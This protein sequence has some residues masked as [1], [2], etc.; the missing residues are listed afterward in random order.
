MILKSFGQRLVRELTIWMQLHHPNVLELYGASAHGPYGFA[1]VSPWMEHGNV[2]RY[3]QSTPEAKRTPL[4]LDVIKGLQY[5]HDRSIVHGNLTGRNVLVNQA[6][7]ACLADF[8]LAWVWTEGQESEASESS[9][10]P[11]GTLRWM[12]PERVIPEHYGMTAAS[13][14]T[15]AADI[16]SFAMVAYEIISGSMPFA[17]IR[18]PYILFQQI[19]RGDRPKRPTSGG[20]Y[21]AFDDALWSTIEDCWKEDWRA[22]PKADI[23]VDEVTAAIVPDRLEEMVRMHSADLSRDREDDKSELERHAETS[24]QEE[25]PQVTESTLP[26]T[27]AI[28]LSLLLKDNPLLQSMTNVTPFLQ[29]V[30]PAAVHTGTRRAIWTAEYNGQRVALKTARIDTSSSHTERVKDLIRE[31]SIWSRLRHPN[32]LELYGFC[33]LES[34]GFAMV[35]RWMENGSLV[36]YLKR[37][38]SASRLPWMYDIAEGLSYLHRQAPPIVHGDLAGRNILIK[39][40][41]GACLADFGLS[42]ILSADFGLSRVFP[43]NMGNEASQTSIARGNP[44]W[45]APERL[46]PQ[47]YGL[48]TSSSLTISSDIYSFGMVVYEL[49]TGRIPFY[50]VSNQLSIPAMVEAGVRPSHPGEE[51]VQLGLSPIVWDMMQECWKEDYNTRPEGSR[52]VQMIA[53]LVTQ[54]D[55]RQTR[56]YMDSLKLPPVIWEEVKPALTLTRDITASIKSISDRPLG[57]GGLSDVWTGSYLGVKVA[58]KARMRPPVAEDERI[59]V[60]VKEIAIRARLFHPNILELYGFSTHEPPGFAMV[61][62][63]MQHGDLT[64]YLHASVGVPRVQLMLDIAEGLSYLHS[65]EPPIVHC[66]LK[67][68]NVLIKNDG[69]ACIAGFSL[70]R[71]LAKDAGDDLEEEQAAMGNIRWMA[72]ERAFPEKHGL[73]TNVSAC[74]PAADVYSFGMVVYEVFTEAIPYQGQVDFAVVM[75]V[76]NRELP[77][78]P[79]PE[80]VERGLGDAMWSLA[81]DCWKEKRDERPTATE[82][83]RRVSDLIKPDTSPVSIPHE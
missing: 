35:S 81:Q 17:E 7:Q 11:L 25:G 21:S 40:D 5:L 54:D 8:G 26:V 46:Q 75:K 65:F 1:L 23:V 14:F 51:A 33:E 72:P 20:E 32:I 36:E 42:R 63:W 48:D 15:P 64:R 16:Y 62:P 6:G 37:Y 71:F 67:A 34:S 80:A 12:A 24:I 77:P 76:M 43:G 50:E 30:S 57:L 79:G 41:G 27:S 69:R 68:N 38:P 58:L 22:R 44:R 83:V 52:I 78:H 61:S 74:T 4:V 49:F 82:L 31:I 47:N 60:T 53:A 39:A 45:M 3:L 28:P 56:S 18:N 9:E 10:S 70:A 73:E 19:E 59:V 29:N 55:T 2:A 66:D 13:S